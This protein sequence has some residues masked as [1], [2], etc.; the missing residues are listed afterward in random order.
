MPR[1]RKRARTGTLA[2]NDTT[3]HREEASE[4]HEQS[5]INTVIDRTTTF[6]AATGNTVTR[7]LERS[8]KISTATQRSLEV[9]NTVSR[10]RNASDQTRVIHS[11]ST[12]TLLRATVDNLTSACASFQR[13]KL[14]EQKAI[15]A[16]EVAV[17]SPV[18]TAATVVP[19]SVVDLF[20]IVGATKP[21]T[22]LRPRAF[23]D[24][25]R[26]FGEVPRVPTAD[27][28]LRAVKCYEC[29]PLVLWTWRQI[30]D[31]CA[32][33]NNN[34]VADTIIARALIQIGRPRMM[35]KNVR[36]DPARVLLDSYEINDKHLV[37]CVVDQNDEQL[38]NGMYVSIED[39]DAALA[40][41]II[42]Q[43]D[44][45][46]KQHIHGQVEEFAETFT[47]SG[48]PHV[49]MAPPNSLD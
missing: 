4:R 23:K 15:T 42:A 1:P 37:V 45:E 44:D 13:A 29:A 7:E 16:P 35:P 18:V 39:C 19:N 36:D 27:D 5:N 26:L 38:R 47:R 14:H 12:R 22:T 8:H 3:T 28:V 30:L 49:L 31:T 9:A 34:D 17:T 6:D 11:A 10:S 24:V 46:A 21:V 2:T 32:N 40:L 41:S 20:D 25:S 33:L 43:D 48:L